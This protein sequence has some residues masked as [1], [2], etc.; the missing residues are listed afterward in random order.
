[1]MSP[2]NISNDI[3]ASSGFLEELQGDPNSS[4]GTLT[5]SLGETA[6]TSSMG[7]WEEL[8]YRGNPR[9]MLTSQNQA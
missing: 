9:I 2:P 5:F 7:T 4:P 6:I 8:G 3:F 1:M